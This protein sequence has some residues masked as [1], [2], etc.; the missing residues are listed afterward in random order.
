MC[1]L[2]RLT[3]GSYKKRREWKRKE[4]KSARSLFPWNKRDCGP[5]K[6]KKLVWGLGGLESPT[7]FTAGNPAHI[8]Y[9]QVA[10]GVKGFYPRGKSKVQT[11]VVR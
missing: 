3:L 11:S 10:H 6:N 5:F 7:G 4:K 9:H 8:V 1:R 2:G